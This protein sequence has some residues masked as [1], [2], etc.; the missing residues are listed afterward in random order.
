MKPI[1]NL[2]HLKIWLLFCSTLTVMA[3][4]TL[5]PALPSMAGSFSTIDNIDTLIKLVI[6]LPGIFIA[7]TAFSMGYYLDRYSKYKILFTCLL[8]YGVFGCFGYVYSQ[9]FLA[10]LV[11]RAF[12]GIAVAGIMVAVT[13]IAAEVFSGKEL[14]QYMGLQAAFGSIGG[15]VFM[16]L[17]GFLAEVNWTLPFLVHS[18]A[19][20][21]FCIVPFIFFPEL[22]SRSNFP[23]E[24]KIAEISTTSSNGIRLGFFCSL[25]FIEI[26]LLYL[27]PLQLPF[28]FEHNLHLSTSQAGASI[29]L[30]FTIVALVSMFYGKLRG[31][32]RFHILHLI[33]FIGLALGFLL[34]GLKPNLAVFIIGLVCISI[35]FGLV[36]PNLIMWLFSSFPVHQRGRVMGIV[37]SFY[38]LGQFACLWV[39]LPFSGSEFEYIVAASIALV[40][41][42]MIYRFS[43][44]G[45]Q[46]SPG[47]KPKYF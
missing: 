28:Y 3:G 39:F 41:A 2:R 11:S 18:L 38:F 23:V 42:L 1:G 4:A 26:L 46:T 43:R 35:G 40:V 16:V 13:V 44:V 21:L 30:V 12:V 5:A 37:T 34:M 8:A 15:V 32:I 25:A 14:P 45:L 36:R 20:F 9:N 17:S 24:K 10:I 27:I 47:E 6:V 19:L 7:I 29:A 22:N 31:S 33:G